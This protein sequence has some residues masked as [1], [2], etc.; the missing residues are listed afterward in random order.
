MA[1]KYYWNSTGVWIAGSIWV[2]GAVI[3]T[4]VYLWP[5]MDEMGFYAFDD[6]FAPPAEAVE[7]EGC[8]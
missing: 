8:G 1:Y 3:L 2:I 4:V 7:D 5:W 6:M